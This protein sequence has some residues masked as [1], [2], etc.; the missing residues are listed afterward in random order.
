MPIDPHIPI[1]PGKPNDAKNESMPIGGVNREPHEPIV[2][3]APYGSE[4]EPV[5][6]A[7]VVVPQ[8]AKEKAQAKSDAAATK[9]ENEQDEDA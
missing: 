8:T 2:P 9:K 4:P 5:V 3:Q 7:S 6:A 1:V